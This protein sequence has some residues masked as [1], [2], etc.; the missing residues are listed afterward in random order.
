MLRILESHYG[1][2][3]MS[4]LAADCV[5]VP[6][7]YWEQHDVAEMLETEAVP[8]R[9]EARTEVIRE[10]V[11]GALQLS[12]Y[13]DLIEPTSITARS[14]EPDSIAAK[15]ERRSD[16]R[17]ISDLHAVKIVLAEGDD[18]LLWEI[19]DYLRNFFGVP[20]FQPCGEPTISFLGNDRSHER[21]RDLHIP[22]AKLDI[23]FGDETVLFEV[24][25]MTDAQ[26][27]IYDETRD[28]Y[29]TSRRQHLGEQACRGA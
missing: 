4:S 20:E 16:T 17:P 1:P 7:T 19:Q 14:K 5:A 22:Q 12:P 10:L 9:M 13:C 21:F 28:Y 18:A 15:I 25:V 11:A 29:E 3:S 24:L 2:A 26:R 8:T 6:T 23:V 27:S